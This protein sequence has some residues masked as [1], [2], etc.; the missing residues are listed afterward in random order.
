M[1]LFSHSYTA[2]SQRDLTA[3]AI[4]QPLR[5]NPPQQQC[6]LPSTAQLCSRSA[7][8]CWLCARVTGLCALSCWPFCARRRI[9]GLSCWLRARNCVTGS[10]PEPATNCPGTITGNELLESDG[11]RGS[12][13]SR[14]ERV[15]GSNSANQA[16]R[17]GA[18]PGR[19]G[20][21][22]EAAWLHGACCSG[23]LGPG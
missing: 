18:G 2:I 16:V 1:T 5:T 3:I 13:P 10:P 20:A 6:A 9:A 22:R 15:P 8:S 19:H 21:R 11:V 23:S 14:R 7:Q 17:S 4:S 12:T